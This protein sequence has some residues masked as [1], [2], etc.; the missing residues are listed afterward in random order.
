MYGYQV[1]GLHL[2]SPIELADLVAAAPAAPDAEVV[3]GEA[4]VAPGGATWTGPNWRLSP[5]RFLLHIPQT[6]RISVEGG[7][8]ID[9]EPLG[10]TA[11]H[12]LAALVSGGV[13]LATLLHQRRRLALRASAVNVGGRAVLFCG[14]S[15]T[16]KST[17]AA[18]LDRRGHAFLADD[19]CALDLAADGPPIV[20]P[21][22]GRLLLWP[23]AIEALGLASGQPVR[24]GLSKRLVAPA[25]A[26]ASPAPLGLV[27]LLRPRQ[28]SAPAAAVSAWSASDATIRLHAAAPALAVATRLGLDGAYFA[29][30]SMIA[31]RASVCDLARPPGWDSL[32]AVIDALERHW[33][34]LAQGGPAV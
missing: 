32:D 26:A 29:A 20:W 7:R 1:A 6:A 4:P 34:H 23:A 21:D 31:R 11:P 10:G 2:R 28:P 16:G 27:Y 5:D 24:P 18:A 13:V 12:A 17:L 14:A 25:A 15:G 33:S 22:R 30:A 8:R 19:L 3:I 9:V